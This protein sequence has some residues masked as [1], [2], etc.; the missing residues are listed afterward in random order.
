MNI[1]KLKR[2]EAQFLQVYP[3]G[4]LHPDMQAIAKK[5]R[6]A[7]MS[8]LT[9]ESFS[10]KQF[11]TPLTITENMSKII[12]RSSMVSMFEKPKF[13]DAIKAM[14]SDMKHTLAN[15]LK[16]LLHGNQQQGFE[17]M[18]QVLAHY[19]L[20]KWSL[21]TILP[22]YFSPDTEVFVKPNTTKGIIRFFELED[23]VY[24]PQPTWNFYEQ[25]R[26]S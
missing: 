5:H 23:L 3:Q 22:N 13:R 21:I 7:Q 24:K 17:Q 18:V 10:K 20:A 25:Y 12:G 26:A 9:Q 19:K 1:Q 6:L 14:D 8:S 2:A 11:S 4:F 16:K 15:G